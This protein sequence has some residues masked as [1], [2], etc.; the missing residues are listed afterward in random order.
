MKW[1]LCQLCRRVAELETV[2]NIEMRWVKIR[3]NSCCSDSCESDD[4][5]RSNVLDF[6]GKRFVISRGDRRSPIFA[7]DKDRR[8]IEAVVVSAW[9]FNE[10]VLQ[11]A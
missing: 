9:A 8:A 10:K 2:E 4:M 7:G 6:I 3:I 5:P 11:K 1:I